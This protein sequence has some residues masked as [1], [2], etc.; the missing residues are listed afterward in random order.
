MEYLLTP[1]DVRKILKCSL[2]LIYKM[3]GRGQ[4]PCI[5]WECP[6]VGTKKPRTTVRFKPSDVRAFIQKHCVTP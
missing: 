6:G 4:L 5:R 3:A 1:K 2:P